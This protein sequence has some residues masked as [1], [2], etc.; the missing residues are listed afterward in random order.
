MMT[1]LFSILPRDIL[2]SIL[3]KIDNNKIKHIVE[4]V[5]LTS[6]DKEYIIDRVLLKFIPKDRLIEYIDIDNLS[7][8][9][10]NT[11]TEFYGQK[12]GDIQCLN[13]IKDFTTD[14]FNS[15]DNDDVLLAPGDSPS[16]IIQVM[17]INYEHNP[18]TF[19]MNGFKKRIKII[20]F[21][22]SGKLFD[23]ERLDKYLFE[24]LKSNNVGPKDNV[25]MIDYKEQ[26]ETYNNIRLS[27]AR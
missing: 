4:H 21:P 25:I 19:I 26:G 27:M 12:Y 3:I 9:D 10:I 14:I 20:S 11:L 13:I 15:L 16:K 23:D 6:Q 2:I 1:S 24:I 22:L 8:E 7:K 18:G 5:D 17:K